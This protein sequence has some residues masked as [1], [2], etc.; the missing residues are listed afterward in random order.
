[1]RVSC[2]QISSGKNIQKNLHATRNLILKSIRQKADFIITPECS[3]LFGLNKKQLLR[4]TTSMKEDIYLNGIKKIAKKYKKWILTSIIVKEKK[5]IK[6]RSVLIN[7][8]GL[9]QTYYD[10]INMYDAVL[11]NKEKYF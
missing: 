4:Q 8:N 9:V 2:I 6:N 5:K 7:T 1:M 10:K 11:S 3:S